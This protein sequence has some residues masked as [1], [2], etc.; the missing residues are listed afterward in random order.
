[1]KKVIKIEPANVH[2]P[3]K[4]LRV[5]AYY[6]VSSSMADQLVS[7][8]AQKAHYEEYITSNPEWEFAGLYYD[9][10]ISGTKKEKRQA[11]LQMMTDCENG[12]ID[13][14]VTK[15]LSRFARNT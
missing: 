1:M 8:D 4:R 12:K 9:E 13:F 7:L 2:Q 15:S 11:L 3:K 6:R 5:A 10:G 14:I